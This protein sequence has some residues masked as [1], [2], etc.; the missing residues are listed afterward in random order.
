MA[1]V[2]YSTLL[3]YSTLASVCL[4]VN[5]GNARDGTRDTPLPV[6]ALSAEELDRTGPSAAEL[7]NWCPK[8]AQPI[9]VGSNGVVGSGAQFKKKAMSAATGLVGGLLGVG[10]GGGGRS[11][12]P[13][14]VRC[15]MKNKNMTVFNDP[16]TGISL[17][18][19]A[20]RKG[21]NVE[22][23]SRVND[24][25]DRGTFQTT[26]V[27][28]DGG[29]FRTP[30]ELGMCDLYGEFKLSVSWTKDTYVNG[31]HVDHQEG[32][33]SEIG[34]FKI[35]GMVS[36]DDA[37][38]GYWNMLGFSN[39][40][41]GARKIR[42]TFAIP[43]GQ[44]SGEPIAFTV[45]VTT[46]GEDPVVTVPFTV[47]MNETEDGFQFSDVPQH[48]SDPALIADSDEN[49]QGFE[50][51]AAG[52]A[53]VGGGGP[54][55][56]IV[57]GETVT[58]VVIE[59]PRNRRLRRI[60]GFDENGQ[61][62]LE[63]KSAQE[64]KF[65]HGLAEAAAKAGF[66]SDEAAKDF[67][68]TNARPAELEPE[69][70]DT[71]N[72]RARN[73]NSANN[74]SIL[75]E[76]G[77]TSPFPRPEQDKGEA[78]GEPS[79]RPAPIDFSEIIP[80]DAA[81]KL[82]EQ[83]LLT[84]EA[85]RAF[86][87]ENENNAGRANQSGDLQSSYDTRLLDGEAF[88]LKTQTAQEFAD[89][90]ADVAEAINTFLD[91]S[92]RFRSKYS[93]VASTS[94]EL[95]GLLDNWHESRQVFENVDLAF[96]LINLTA[97]GAKLGVKSVKWFSKVRADRAA[98]KAAGQVDEALAAA[99]SGY[100]QKLAKV[101]IDWADDLAEAEKDLAEAIS[102]GQPQSYIDD[103]TAMIERTRQAGPPSEVDDVF[104]TGI[105]KLYRHIDADV[106]VRA[107]AHD[108]NVD[109]LIAKTATKLDGV[110]DAGDVLLIVDDAEWLLL[111]GVATKNGWHAIPDNIANSITVALF[112]GRQALA[113]LG[114]GVSPQ[115]V[116]LLT[117][118]KKALEA[119]NIDLGQ[120]LSTTAGEVANA[121]EY[122][123]TVTTASGQVQKVKRVGDAIEGIMLYW[124]EADIALIEAIIESGGDVHKMR[125]QIS[126]IAQASLNGLGRN[127]D[128]GAAAASMG[129]G[130]RLG[131]VTLSG[132]QA[133]VDIHL[134]VVTP[135]IS[136]AELESALFSD[137][138]PAGATGTGSDAAGSR[139][140]LAENVLGV[141]AS[142][143]ADGLGGYVDAFG[144]SNDTVLGEIWD[145]LSE[146]VTTTASHYY[147]H[148]ALSAYDEVLSYSQGELIEMVVA[149]DEA[150]S[151]LTTLSNALGGSGRIGDA[152]YLGGEAIA[153]LEAMKTAYQE[154]LQ[155]ASPEWQIAHGVDVANRIDDIDQMI[156]DLTESLADLEAL[157]TRVQQIHDWLQSVRI[158]ANG[159][160]QPTVA[161]FN[162]IAF[163]RATSASLILKA[164]ASDA[165]GLSTEPA[166]QFVRVT[167]ADGTVGRERQTQWVN[168]D[169]TLNEGDPFAEGSVIESVVRMDFGE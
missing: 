47:M 153:E 41:A 15:K 89:L 23:F 119:K 38:A 165:F 86:D 18:V 42:T 151:A 91:A 31:Q 85:A 57:G 30:I 63:D 69:A 104:L 147:T 65:A 44:A 75:D 2:N 81:A 36:S 29:D 45:H 102:T 138:A 73:A 111:R 78:K 68:L 106:L 54:G 53:V 55:G 56:A 59:D 13:T 139:G 92:D 128:E 87:L 83:G 93:Y 148:E 77:A 134:T 103:L 112:E 61:A 32:G 5:I 158:D 155:T 143:G 46:P 84:P 108:L 9:E 135:V 115:N 79:I 109:A 157:A 98:A 131:E 12:G 95:Q 35:P 100:E 152:S 120:W 28:R 161:L 132:A 118:L 3:L 96:A 130:A 67:G 60:V 169:G 20:R 94:T 50:M 48:C 90:Q 110:D 33:W 154:T 150:L 122:F 145:F 166:F 14:T 52:A 88:V 133:A 137:S 10:G 113:G 76:V 121:A 124:D 114:D 136:A 25:P 107:R 162:P 116:E 1:R 99:V 17:Q 58:P 74:S 72:E 164:M 123:E 117:K 105:E 80:A 82:A 146:P 51:A 11:S 126:E 37:P 4:P 168:F 142:L 125:T 19:G 34:N 24:S 141:N 101:K 8:P 62:I 27:E 167:Q 127:L 156:A 26:Y 6:S 22:I 7:L 39:A 66:L 129:G 16:L 70:V 21:D 40:S 97:G 149:Y 163:V 159:A 140:Q 64:D 160:P 49:A 144:V 43:E 71:T